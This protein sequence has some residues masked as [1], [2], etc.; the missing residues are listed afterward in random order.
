MNTDILICKA[1]IVGEHFPVC[2]LLGDKQLKVPLLILGL[3]VCFFVKI[4]RRDVK[5]LDKVGYRGEKW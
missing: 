3:G 4:V 5:W 1:L 2:D